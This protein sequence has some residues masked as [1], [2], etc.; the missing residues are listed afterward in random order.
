[1]TVD[2]DEECTELIFEKKES[3]YAF[4]LEKIPGTGEDVFFIMHTGAGL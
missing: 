4:D 2:V 1:M 3:Q